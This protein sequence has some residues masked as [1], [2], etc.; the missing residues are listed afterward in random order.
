MK[1]QAWYMRPDWF[2]SGITGR[3]P[4]AKDLTATHVLLRTVETDKGLGDVFRKMQGENW[5]PAGE[6]RALIESKGLQHTS[7]SPGDVIV[8]DVGNAHVVANIGFKAIGGT[9]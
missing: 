1:Y 6:A 4:N 2:Y 7:M 8:D 5:S 9:R 3:L